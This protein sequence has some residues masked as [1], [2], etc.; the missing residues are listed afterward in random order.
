MELLTAQDCNLIQMIDF[1]S[2]PKPTSPTRWGPDSVTTGPYRISRE[3]FSKLLIGE[4]PKVTVQKNGVDIGTGDEVKFAILNRVGN[5]DLNNRMKLVLDKATH[6]LWGG[7]EEYYQIF[8]WL[9][10]GNSHSD[11]DSVDNVCFD[12]GRR[13]LDKFEQHCV[14]CSI[15][16][17]GL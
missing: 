8:F 13:C 9:K 17:V 7:K 4:I 5:H 15:A 2:K 10:D 14:N 11:L 12:C 6:D 1:M 3:S 16:K